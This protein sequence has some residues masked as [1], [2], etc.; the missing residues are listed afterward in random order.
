MG[1]KKANSGITP[2]ELLIRQNKECYLIITDE[3]VPGEF[4]LY[5]T[6]DKDRAP[7]ACLTNPTVECSLCMTKFILDIFSDKITSDA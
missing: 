4:R 1:N 6:D 7:A 3:E 2:A 5:C